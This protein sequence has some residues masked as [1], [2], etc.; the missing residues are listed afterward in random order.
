MLY[1]YTYQSPLPCVLLPL[2]LLCIIALYLPILYILCLVASH[3]PL[4]YSL[5]L[6]NP[7]HLVSCCLSSFFALQPYTFQSPIPM[8]LILLCVITLYLPIPFILCLVAFH[9]PLC[10][11]LIVSIP[12]T[13]CLVA[14][15]SRLCYNL[16]LTNPLYLVSCCLSFSFVL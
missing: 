3:S 10:Y 8:P 6:T 1:P 13:L 7:V 5:I 12:Y 4:S 14:S 9:P 11:S 16:I 15:D 2:I